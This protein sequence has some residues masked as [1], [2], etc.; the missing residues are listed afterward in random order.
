[1]PSPRWK[2]IADRVAEL[3]RSSRATGAWDPVFTAD[4]R[5]EHTLRVAHYGRAIAAG[6]GVDEDLALAGSLLHDV[7]Y[8]ATGTEE[9]W[10]DHGRI[11][12]RISR[13]LLEAA[14]YS[15]AEC[16]AV[17]HAVAV[18]VDG[19]S[20]DGL[21]GTVLDAVVSDADNVDRF[22]AYRV[23]AW[24][25]TERDDLQ[26]MAAMPRERLARLYRYRAESPLETA[27]GRALFAAQVELQITMFEALVRDA[28]LSRLPDVRS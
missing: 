24:C 15:T 21:A 20:D 2:E 10:D 18:H 3:A 16:D 14:G 5:W 7:A 6:E 19:K 8:F 22:S 13:P 25:M 12:A 1:M 4:Y 9:D 23:I 26:K 17:C 27:T 28:E 11:G